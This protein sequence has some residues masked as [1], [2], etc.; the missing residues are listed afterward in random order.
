[1]IRDKD[2]KLLQAFILYG[3]DPKRL[4][5][6]IVRYME[7]CDRL[8]VDTELSA[9]AQELC[10]GSV[11]IVELKNASMIGKMIVELPE[12]YGIVVAVESP[13]REAKAIALIFVNDYN[14]RV[15]EKI[16]R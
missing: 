4:F 8:V 3:E 11:K 12:G 13:I 5:E 15:C 10:G 1:L 6:R 14:K 2:L 9:I 16:C 7:G